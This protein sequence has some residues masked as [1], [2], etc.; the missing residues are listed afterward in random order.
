M[1]RAS[2]DTL[3]CLALRGC[4]LVGDPVP[5]KTI[6]KCPWVPVGGTRGVGIVGVLSK[7]SRVNYGSGEVVVLTLS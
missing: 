1:L 3:R 5:E 6:G 2:T 4:D 7:E